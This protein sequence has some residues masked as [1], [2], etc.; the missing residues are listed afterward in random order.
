MA[1]LLRSITRFAR[2]PQGRRM[3]SRAAQKAEEVAKDPATRAKIERARRTV[4][5]PR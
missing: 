5:R 1:S 3:I 2:T 4:R